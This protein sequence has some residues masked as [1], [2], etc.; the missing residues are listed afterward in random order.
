MSEYWKW[1]ASDDRFRW[2]DA[3]VD[4]WQF[5]EQG[6]LW[7]LCQAGYVPEK[8]AYEIGAGDGNSLPITVEPAY[9][10]N[11]RT[12][13]YEIDPERQLALREN[14]PNAYIHGRFIEPQA[15]MADSLVVIDIDRYDVRIMQSILS[16]NIFPAV[17]MV[18]HYD[19]CGPCIGTEP[20]LSDVPDWLLGMRLD[21][22]GFTIQAPW[23]RLDAIASHYDY[24]LIGISRVNSIFVYNRYVNKLE[25]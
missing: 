8:S 3:F 2:L 25:K 10:A 21:I 20:N 16:K 19:T 15:A 17:M 14:F 7:A 22:G 18:E 23:K 4:G 5:G 9:D 24:T 11:W 13:L 6:V 1:K 12:V